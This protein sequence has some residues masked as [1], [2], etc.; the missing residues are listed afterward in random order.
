[1]DLTNAQ[2]RDIETLIHPYTNLDAFRQTGPVVMERGEGIHVWDTNGKQYIEGLAGL[3]CTSLGYNEKELIEA[4]TQQLA[5]LPYT[6]TFAGKS[7]ERAIELAEAVKEISP[8]P[9]SKVLFCGSGSEAN[10]QQIKLIWYYNNARGKTEK[11]KIISRKRAYHGVT[12]ATASLTGLVPNQRDFDLPIDRIHHVNCPFAYR[13]AEPGETDDQFT[14]RLAKELDQFIE[15]EG[16]DTV[17]AFFAEPIQGAGGVL[18]PADGY[19]PKIKKV[20]DKHDVYF[21][22][23]EVICGFGR[24]GNMFGSQTFDMQPDSISV[25][26][27]L[28]SAYLPIGAI[29]IGDQMYEAMLEESRKIGTFGHGYTYTAHPVCAAVAIK[30]LE[31]YK[32]RD[33]VG[34]VRKLAPVFEGRF[35]KLADHPLVGNARAKGLIGAVELV[36]DKATKRSFDPAQ[37]VGITCQ[38]N[39]EAEGLLSRALGGDIVAL[40]PPLIIQEDEVN[41]MFDRLERAL[42]ATEHWVT[43]EGLRTA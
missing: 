43:K 36:A 10:D 9:T 20:L 4:A 33:I 40:C 41:E 6:H 42:D 5:T 19:F 21:V 7:H 1:M 38:M 29:T 15:H 11:K 32:K 26:K 37:K 30:T 35:A 39:A 27:A 24:T 31:I 12:V 28:S 34:H 16:P 23:D 25:A 3:W 17:A 13:E 14:D 22:A 8:H 18:I 2:M